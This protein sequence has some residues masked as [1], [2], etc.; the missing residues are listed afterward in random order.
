MDLVLIHRG[1]SIVKK[2]VCITSLILIL[3]LGLVACGDVP[4]P[5]EPKPDVVLKDVAESLSNI[6]L[7]ESTGKDEKFALT[8]PIQIEEMELDWTKESDN[9]EAEIIAY[10]GDNNWISEAKHNIKLHYA[11]N[12]SK[13]WEL[14][15][16]NVYNPVIHLIL[17]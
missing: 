6:I 8:H 13:E 2:I 10:I 1:N 15:G 14:Q 9:I 17:R 4:A 11:L 7:G 3:S 12:A 16:A 5:K